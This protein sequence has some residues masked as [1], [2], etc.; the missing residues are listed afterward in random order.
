MGSAVPVAQTAAPV[1]NTASHPAADR[2]RALYERPVVSV[3]DP[4]TFGEVKS[5]I[6]AHFADS[7]IENF[8]RALD[9]AALRVREFE[10]VVAAGKLGDATAA[11]Y[12]RLSPGDQG[13][14]RELYLASLERVALPLRDRFFKLYAYY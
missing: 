9:R 14:V 7:G 12:A 2:T 3:D 6:D 13:Q 1:N 4:V 10:G 11:Q 5:S 8:L